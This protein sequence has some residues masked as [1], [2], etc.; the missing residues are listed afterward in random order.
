MRLTA[1][2]AERHLLSLHRDGGSLR[3]RLSKASRAEEEGT[4]GA[5]ETRASIS[6]QIRQKHAFAAAAR[7]AIEHR[8][9]DARQAASVLRIRTKSTASVLGV[10]PDSLTAFA[11]LAVRFVTGSERLDLLAVKMDALA[12]DCQDACVRFDRLS[13]DINSSIQCSLSLAELVDA[14]PEAGFNPRLGET[15]RLR[16][17]YTGWARQAKK[18]AKYAKPL[19]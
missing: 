8:G 10:S 2:T 12:R 18:D 16:R 3:H 19:S 17:A 14:L 13:G 11:L 15:E 5:A 7:S 9:F 4:Q 1:N 6:S